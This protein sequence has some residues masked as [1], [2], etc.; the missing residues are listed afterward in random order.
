MGLISTEL[1]GISTKSVYQDGESYSLVNLRPKNNSLHP[2]APRSSINTLSKEYNIV[3]LHQ[4]FNYENWIGIVNSNSTS[5]IWAF[6]NTE[7]PI[8]ITTIETISSIE[9]IGNTLSLVCENNIYYLL[10]RD[11]QYHFLGNLPDVP[12]V[13]MFV[14]DEERYEYKYSQLFGSGNVNLYSSSDQ[15]NETFNTNIKACANELINI[16]KNGGELQE[17]DTSST[18]TVFARPGLLFDAHLVR[19][20]YRLYDGTYTKHSPVV[21]CMPLTSIYSTKTLYIKGVQELTHID[22]STIRIGV[23]A[24]QL[25][26]DFD[27]SGLSDWKD[28]I[29]SIDI[30]MSPT[31]G[32]SDSSRITFD[33]RQN[34]GYNDK[35]IALINS[36]NKT[37]FENLEALSNFYL[38]RSIELDATT[39]TD[40]SIPQDSFILDNLVY[41][42]ELTDDSFS[43]NIVGA[44]VSYVYNNRLHLANLKTTIYGGYPVNLFS[45]G[46]YGSINGIDQLS[47]NGQF[48]DVVAV[49]S[50]RTFIA[51]VTI[52]LNDGTQ[53]V[54]S[55]TCNIP[56]TFFLQPYISYPDS[57]ATKIDFYLYDNTKYKLLCSFKLKEHSSL[58]LAYYINHENSQEEYTINPITANFASAQ[59][60]NLIP[61]TVVVNEENKLKVS[62]INNPLVFLSVNT[63]VPGNGEILSLASNAIRISEGQFG[64]YPLYVFTNTGIY[65][66]NVGSGDTVYSNAAP[67]SY[68]IPVS[69][70]VCS[71]PF[72]IGF[73]SKRGVCIISGQEVVVLSLELQESHVNIS[74]ERNAKML[75]IVN[76]AIN[77]MD[78]LSSIN[79]IL[80]NA[81]E[82]E[83]IISNSGN[84]NWVY[85]FT[86]KSWYLTTEIIDSVVKNTYPELYVING[87]NIKDYSKSTGIAEVSF[88]TRPIRFNSIYSKRIFKMQLI[89]TLYDAEIVF[90]IHGSDD[91]VNFKLLSGLCKPTT[92]NYARLLS[93]IIAKGKFKEFLF[94]FGA[95]LNEDSVIKTLNSLVD[96][97]YDESVM[98]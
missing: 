68:E 27:I 38:V 30:F 34:T 73:I 25:A 15:D 63:Y 42:E 20:A 77:F 45:W 8:L 58:N 91:G 39:T 10:F 54:Y 92:A 75:A 49:P 76:A 83:L 48:P 7:S 79:N 21:V 1:S 97:E 33:Q 57:R 85:N 90:A 65:S 64:Q 46:K 9:Q 16:L 11:S 43:H 95:T 81:V 66:L 31:A 51:A 69:G 41:K 23:I 84:Y 59:E 70:I 19:F 52:R 53:K 44:K 5:D 96:K 72:G 2:V 74:L 98:K 35:Y 40:L 29:E 37:Q 86:S 3:F 87:T 89:C 18:K 62:A 93:P 14:T 55:Q 82:D 80:Y 71:T 24:Y 17:L 50:S 47:Y 61:A 12:F 67:T 56:N 88:I 4:N 28:I 32:F 94:S 13:R 60:Y 78:Y 6:I 26:F 22:N 36:I